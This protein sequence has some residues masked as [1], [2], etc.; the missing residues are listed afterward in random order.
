M[1]DICPNT[2]PI[3]SGLSGI[4]ASAASTIPCSSCGA[5]FQQF[6]CVNDLRFE[7]L[8][9]MGEIY[10]HTDLLASSIQTLSNI[11]GEV[12]SPVSGGVSSY[13]AVGSE[14]TVSALSINGK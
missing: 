11:A 4:L 6:D 8:L 1:Y 13:S 7:G 5:S 14:W 9:S 3:L 10:N 2:D 12:M